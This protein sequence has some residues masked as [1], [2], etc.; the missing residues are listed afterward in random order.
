MLGQLPAP[1]FAK[2]LGQPENMVVAIGKTIIRVTVIQR[3]SKVR[4]LRL[5]G[6]TPASVG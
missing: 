2:V 3:V 1:T 6:S 5:I 4:F